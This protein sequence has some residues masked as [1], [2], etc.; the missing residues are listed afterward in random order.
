MP[1]LAVRAVASAVRRTLVR[2]GLDRVLAELT[3]GAPVTSL[4]ARLVPSH[5]LYEPPSIRHVVRDGIRF[6]LDISDYMQWC[7]YF[8]LTIEPRAALYSL[9]EPGQT[10]LD[11]GSNVG[12]VL[13]NFARRVGEQ[14]QVFGFEINPQTYRRC[15]RNIAMNTFPNVKLLD[16]GLGDEEGEVFLAKANARN[17][18]GDRIVSAEGGEGTPVRVSTLDQFVRQHGLRRIDL[19]KIDVEGFEM[20]VLRGAEATVMKDRPRLFVELDERNL[21]LQGNSGRELV[22]WLEQFGYG[23]THAA[24]NRPVRPTDSFEGVHF[25]IIARPS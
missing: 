24:E 20:K 4:R 9:M 11:V 7:V 25:D 6:E 19:I 22:E 13:L 14:G 2:T 23:V 21:R 15:M 10:A 12:E 16:I 18:G 5:L 3:P 17:S 8:G 1:G